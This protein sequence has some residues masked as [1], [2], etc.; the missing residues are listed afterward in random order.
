MSCHIGRR[1]HEPDREEPPNRVGRSNVDRAEEEPEVGTG[2]VDLGVR[3]R[4][5][6]ARIGR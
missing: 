1:F 6:D 5:A 2:A 4:D 3:P